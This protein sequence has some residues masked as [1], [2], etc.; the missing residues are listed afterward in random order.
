MCL[1]RLRNPDATKVD[2]FNYFDVAKV[3]L[4]YFIIPNISALPGLLLVLLGRFHPL[5]P[6]QPHVS[7]PPVHPGSSPARP[8]TFHPA[9]RLVAPLLGDGHLP[10]APRR[11]HHEAQVRAGLVWKGARQGEY[12]FSLKQVKSKEVVALFCT[13]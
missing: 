2:Y 11:P 3:V 12:Q 4:S 13:F 1:R 9:A 6:G 7:H 5:E 10:S 8:E